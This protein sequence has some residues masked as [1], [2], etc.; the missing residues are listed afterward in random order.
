MPLSLAGRPDRETA[1]SVIRTAVEAGITLIDTADAYAI[2]HHDIGH[3]ERLIAETFR[4]MGLRVED[5][6]VVVATKGG[7]T[8]PDGDWDRDGRPQHL[9]EACEASLRVLESD[10][11]TLY[12]FHSPDPNVPFTDSIGELARL[13][14]EGKIET[15]G[16][17]NVTAAQIKEASALVPIA[18]VQNAQSVW[19]VGYSKSPVVEH[20]RRHGIIFLAYAPLGGTGR[21]S[22]LGESGA[23]LR[24]SAELEASPQELALAW[25]IHL[26]PVVVPI[27]GASRTSSVLS[28]V[29]AGS[30]ALDARTLSRLTSA[31]R[32]LPGHR[33]LL[34]RVASK[35][36]R[37]VG[38]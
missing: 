33:S 29:K 26:A 3:N 20:C 16:L 28:S 18:S 12:Q 10:R 17:S 7:R 23:V 32:T 24:L 30:I 27:P 14:E 22:R 31:F 38:G 5:G 21:A 2:D 6:P 34:Q 1:K 37:V 25:L 19:D 8:R 36:K 11:I 13:R 4:E 35:L 15:V 9:R